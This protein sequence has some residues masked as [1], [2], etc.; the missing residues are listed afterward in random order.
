MLITQTSLQIYKHPY[1]TDILIWEKRL[2]VLRYTSTCTIL[3]SYKITVDTISLHNRV[4][5]LFWQFTF[6]CFCNLFN[7]HAT[8]RFTLCWCPSVH[9]SEKKTEDSSL[10]TQKPNEEMRT[11]AAIQRKPTERELWNH[12]PWIM[13]KNRWIVFQ[14]SG[15]SFQQSHKIINFIP[16]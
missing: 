13:L 4:S 8:S 10:P 11:I 2:Y 7:L 1:S 15:H 16:K 3:W 14:D 9:N 12:Y 5:S 6:Y